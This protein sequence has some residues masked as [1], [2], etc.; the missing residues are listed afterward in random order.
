MNDDNLSDPTRIHVVGVAPPPA[1]P[2]VDTEPHALIVE[3]LSCY[4]DPDDPSPCWDVFEITP[5]NYETLLRDNIRPR[6]VADIEDCLSGNP[7]SK[8][9]VDVTFDRRTSEWVRLLL[10]RVPELAVLVRRVRELQELKRNLSRQRDAR[11]KLEQLLGDIGTAS[12]VPPAEAT[13]AG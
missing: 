8:L 4:R 6:F 12:A 11:L 5:D 3:D 10:E 13:R 1:P 2:D 9:H 7:N